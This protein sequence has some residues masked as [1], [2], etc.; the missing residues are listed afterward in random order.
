MAEIQISEV[1][2]LP[3]PFSFSLQWGCVWFKG[4]MEINKSNE[5]KSG[6]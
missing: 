5:L 3:A 4:S 6:E 1:G 2:A